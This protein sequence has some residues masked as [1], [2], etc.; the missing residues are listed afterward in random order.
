MR[1]QLAIITIV[2]SVSSVIKAQEEPEPSI[3]VDSRDEI[4][5][6]E[7]L[8][9]TIRTGSG[10]VKGRRVT[11]EY[12]KVHYEFLGIPYAEPPTGRLREGFN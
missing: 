8:T 11:D 5:D 10:P 2:L 7:E 4:E 1:I 12:G 3:D 6:T 9:Q